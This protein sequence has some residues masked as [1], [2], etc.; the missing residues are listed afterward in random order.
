LRALVFLLA[1]VAVYLTLRWF[2]RQQHRTRMRVGSSLVGL[3]LIALAAAGRLPW[4]FA[5]FGALLPLLVGVLQSRPPG[6]GERRSGGGSGGA[7]SVVETGF[8]RMALDH[9]SG[10]MRGQV[11]AGRFEGRHLD[12]LSQGQLLTLLNDYDGTDD[13]SA[14]LLRAYL[15]R[16]LGPEWQEAAPGQR[17]FD[18]VSGEMTR[19]EAYAILGLE[20]GA[21]EEEILEAHGRLIQRVHPDRGGSTFL[22]AKINQARD[23]LVGR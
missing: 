16:T 12:E 3:A 13:E 8:L 20:D 1:L 22:A 11:L 17:A 7:Q 21:T 2:L 4:V 9:D 19:E 23:L 5:L 6:P 14:A 18:G 15:E 10:E